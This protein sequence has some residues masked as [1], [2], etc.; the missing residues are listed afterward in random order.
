M[1]PVKLPRRPDGTIDFAGLGTVLRQAFCWG[2][3][4]IIPPVE[5]PQRHP[6]HSDSFEAAMCKVRDGATQL[7][8][9]ANIGA[10][11]AATPGRESIRQALLRMAEDIRK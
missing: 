5:L 7:E 3:Q 10:G 11:P 2:G 1:S 8:V 9:V 6:P 4:A